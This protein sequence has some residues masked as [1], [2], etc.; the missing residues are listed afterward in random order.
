MQNI[1]TRREFVADDFMIDTARTNAVRRLHSPVPREKV[2]T[3][4]APWEGNGCI[5]FHTV[6]IPETGIIRMYYNALRMSTG[7]DDISGDEVKIC[8]IES[9]DGI[10]WSRPELGITDFGGSKS[11]NIILTKQD[12]PGIREIDNFFVMYDDNPNPAVGQCFKAIMQYTGGFRPDGRRD[13][14]LITL[15]SDDGIRFSRFGEVWDFGTFD[16]LNTVHW[17]AA[18]KKYVCLF[19]SLHDGATGAEYDTNR[20]WNEQ[21]RDIRVSFSDDFISWTAPE[22]VVYSD[23][24][25]IPMYTNCAS[26][27]PGAEHMIIGFPTRYTERS[28]WTPGFDRLCGSG[29]RAERMKLHRR[30]GLAL[31]DCAFMCSRDGMHFTRYDEAFM[32]PGPEHPFNWVYGS[33]YPSVGFVETPGFI[34]G[35]DNEWSFYAKHGHWTK[36]ASELYRYALRQDGFVSLYAGGDERIIVTKPF[37]YGGTRLKINFSTSARG[38]MMIRLI[39]ENAAAVSCELFGDSVNREVDF[40]VDPATFTGKPVTMEIRL[41]DADFYSWRFE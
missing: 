26:P 10:T 19:R 33:C 34:P 27:C 32:R 21:V 41:K 4:D 3:F 14:R 40:D 7:P 23:G 15:V 38:Y 17:N 11:N 35:C 36:G 5:Y 18:L 28:A 39:S 25:D 37:V 16:S 31:T 22:R 6:K 9:R 2:F 12:V 29:A 30:Y 24:L 8:F 13:R 1:G 20:D